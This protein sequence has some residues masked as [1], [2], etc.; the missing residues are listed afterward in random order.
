MKTCR[1]VS[2]ILW[3]S[4][5][6]ATSAVAQDGV[7]V[8]GRVVS[9]FRNFG[10]DL[11]PVPPLLTR[12]LAGG[13][14]FAFDG[15]LVDLRTGT[16]R[17]VPAGLQLLAA[18]PGRPRFLMYAPGSLF[19][20]L[21]ELDALSGA[22]RTLGV[23]PGYLDP[24][25]VEPGDAQYAQAADRLFVPTG[26]R[27]AGTVYVLAI[28]VETGAQVGAGPLFTVR[29]FSP[30][31][32]T[33]DATQAF[34]TEPGQLVAIDLATGGRRVVLTEPVTDL[35]WDD[36][37]ERLIAYVGQTAFLLTRDG[38]TLG[39]AA[40]GDCYR[41][42][43]SAHTDRIYVRRGRYWP[44]GR[45]EDLRVFDSRTFALLGQASV[46]PL[47]GCSVSVLTA[48]G[49][50]RRLRASITGHDVRLAWVNV[51]AASGFVLE[52]GFTPGRTD[53]SVYLGPDPRVT[54]AGVPS[55]TYYLRV[56]GG[57][58]FGGGRPSQEIQVVVP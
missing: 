19:S 39:S 20:A 2:V 56:R 48:P 32:V 6:A 9:A 43:T 34:L 4:V 35:Q 44:T 38:T 1:T 58:E 11:G 54:F 25:P 36:A 50:P 33:P 52:A 57:N 41:F 45:I 23:L 12:P 29:S 26:P 47:G 14:R 5:W 55:G 30:W 15:T 17:P 42:A 16:R 24:H 7:I 53:V 28:D 22:T 8:D 49:P 13:G 3:L 21:V 37:Q 27:S 31:V 40:M 18:D 51:G 10:A 46:P